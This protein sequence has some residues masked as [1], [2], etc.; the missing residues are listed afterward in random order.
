MKGHTMTK[1]FFVIGAGPGIA[2]ETARRFAKEGYDVVLASRNTAKLEDQVAVLRASGQSI[3]T[4]TVDASDG[5]AV[6]TLIERYAD[7]I[8]VLLYNAAALVWGPTI[9]ELAAESLDTDI[10]V[11]LSSGLRAVKAVLPAMTAKRS[12]TILLTG[13][14]LADHPH[15]S[16][17]TLSAVKAGL[18]TAGQA[19]FDPLK[20]QNVHIATVTV[21]AS[22][23]PGSLE[24]REIAEKFWQAHATSPEA[25]TYE[26]RY[27]IT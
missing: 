21:S 15:P 7:R 12:G 1:T 14:G 13:G 8:D 9:D 25:W 19:L 26:H 27:S 3:T 16:G 17:L 5:P 11:G 18:R 6:T 20:D 2:F 24:A 10:Q 23:A 4:E 22:V